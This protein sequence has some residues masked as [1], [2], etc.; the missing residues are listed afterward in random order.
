MGVHSLSEREPMKRANFDCADQGFEEA[1]KRAIESGYSYREWQFV[2][3][4]ASQTSA[5]AAVRRLRSVISAGTKI[6]VLASARRE[7][8][9]AKPVYWKGPLGRTARVT[10]QV[11][12]LGRVLPPARHPQ[13]RESWP[14]TMTGM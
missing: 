4:P 8:C 9:W 6:D 5:P 12:F 10:V 7:E 11:R 3:L 2:S 13:A 1:A 14:V